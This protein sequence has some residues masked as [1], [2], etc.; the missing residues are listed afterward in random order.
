MARLI[1]IDPG[2]HTVK[3]TALSG[4]GEEAEIEGTWTQRVPHDPG[5]RPTVADR[6][7]ALDLLLR[8]HDELAS[9]AHLAAV[10]WPLD[11]TSLRLL[12]LPF[13][14][15]DQIAQTLPF[16]LEAEVPFELEEVHLAWTRRPG[17]HVQATLV[18]REE[19]Q[20]LLD[21]LAA[22]GVDPKVVYTEADVLARYASSPGEVVAV[23]DVGEAHTSVVVAR[24][25]TSLTARAL[26]MG[27]ADLVAAVASSL[28][29]SMRDARLLLG[30][31]ADALDDALREPS[32]DADADEGFDLEGF[33]DDEDAPIAE[34]QADDIEPTQILRPAS[35]DPTAA[36]PP[37]GGA[38]RAARTAVPHEDTEDL[39]APSPDE[40]ETD[41]SVG[42]SGLRV[43]GLPA[44]AKAA[45]EA[46][47]H[48]LVAEVRATLVAAEDGL[49]LGVDG[50]V[51]TGGGALIEGVSEALSAD[52]DLTVRAPSDAGGAVPREAATVRA[53]AWML[54][55]DV[56]SATDLRT[57]DLAF[58]GGLDLPRAIL[59]YGG[60]GLGLFV[61]TLL[62]GFGYQAWSL[63]S[64]TA[65][66]D[67]RTLT[68]VA[69]VIDVPD[70]YDARQAAMLLSEVV[71]DNQEQVAFLGEEGEA[72]PTVDLIYQLTKGFPP[73]PD[74]TVTVSSIDITPEQVRVEGSTSG[75]AQVDRIGASLA[76][77][78]HF[79]AVQ[80]E[81][82]N[83][84]RDNELGFSV[85]AS[86]DPDAVLAADD[87][88]G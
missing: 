25:G 60:I 77:S 13:D 79:G 76:E 69:S 9:T 37:P 56:P 51:L 18:P 44:R 16:A 31:A 33:E 74:V 50:V 28:G 14:S 61:L 21:G 17:G 3:V 62:L 78:G 67:E 6:L 43:E 2:A 30:D 59:G 80:A 22:R 86:R 23:V 83:F 4:S 52:L 5:Q 38:L 41:P 48:A 46:A 64:R 40:D 81:G 85:V 88:E 8:R 20:E 1:A 57:G 19:V 55:E 36:P 35:A 70:S 65:S 45:L 71:Y 15:D 53:L 27:A 84:N 42:V 87:E 7:A 75:Y 47:I 49:A 26:G 34:V 68:A 29:C 39:A 54:H 24:E 32:P 58:R 63:S 12:D 73:H 82:G 66:Y 11:R 10:V 72:P